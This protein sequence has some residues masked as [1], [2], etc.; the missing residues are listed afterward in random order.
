MCEHEGHCVSQH[1]KGEE[2]IS[3]GMLASVPVTYLSRTVTLSR[4]SW[5][6]VQWMS[7]VLGVWGARKNCFWGGVNSELI[8]SLMSG[9]EFK[10]VWVSGHLRG[11]ILK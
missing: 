9:V 4:L 1:H 6:V 3:N 10:G 8:P 5:A 7:G 2:T 11:R